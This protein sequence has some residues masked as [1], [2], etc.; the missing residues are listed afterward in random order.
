[1][2]TVQ[3]HLPGTP[4]WFDLMTPDVARAR[5]FYGELL[6]WSFDVGPAEAGFYTQC[7]VGERNAA[8]MGQLPP[9]APF[10]TAWTVYFSVEDADASAAR[11]RERGG[12]V[13]MGPMDVFDAGR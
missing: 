9:G 3:K 2:P 6:G 13:V 10:P 8:G 7:K 1:M 4:S 11:I 5:A 12:Q